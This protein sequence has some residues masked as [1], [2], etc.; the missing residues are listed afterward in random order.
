MSKGFMFLFCHIFSSALLQNQS[1]KG[2]AQKRVCV[3]LLL[4]IQKI[5]ALL[6][7]KHR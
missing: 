4:P 5:Q 2:R 6:V 3:G 1:R 7:V